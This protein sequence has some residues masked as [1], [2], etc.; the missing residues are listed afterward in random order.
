[1]AFVE[2]MRNKGL[3]DKTVNL[4]YQA[5]L[6]FANSRKLELGMKK[7]D[8]PKFTQ[9]KGRDVEIYEQEEW[10]A[11]FNACNPYER[12]VFEFFLN[13]GFREGEVTHLYWSD[14]DFKRGEV[15]VTPKPEYNF[16]AKDY[17]IRHVP[18]SD[19][20][21]AKLKAQKAQSNDNCPL[22]FPT[23]GCKP[24]TQFLDMLKVAAERAGLNPK[25]CKLKKFRATAITNWLRAG[26]DV[27]TVRSWAGHSDLETTANYLRPND[28]IN[29]SKLNG[30]FSASAGASL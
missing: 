11:L 9:K 6:G 17:E 3:T 16:T 5:I 29:R 21:V 15:S 18:I 1:L 13:S 27:E 14:I 10:E 2:F 26:F 22:V 20:L 25:K 4:K 23:L 8:R 28:K 24:Q 7:G 30:V 12:L 19:G